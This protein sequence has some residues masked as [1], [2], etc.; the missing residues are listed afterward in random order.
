LDD[1]YSVAMSNRSTDAASDVSRHL[2]R[3]EQVQKLF[4]IKDESTSR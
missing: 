4:R 3:S 2:A 1:G